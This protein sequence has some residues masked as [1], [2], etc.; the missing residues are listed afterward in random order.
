M[1]EFRVYIR[2]A[3]GLGVDFDEA[4]EMKRFEN[5]FYG[6]EEPEYR[7]ETMD[8]MKDVVQRGIGFKE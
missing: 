7:N 1:A 6:V 8:Y 5:E 4:K 3:I 2:D